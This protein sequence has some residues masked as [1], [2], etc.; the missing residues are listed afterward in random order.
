MLVFIFFVICIVC[1]DVYYEK[2]LKLYINIF[3][4]ISIVDISVNCLC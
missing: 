3:K 1:I 4:C 2:I